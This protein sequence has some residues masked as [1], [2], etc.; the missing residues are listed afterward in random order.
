MVRGE[1]FLPKLKLQEEFLAKQAAAGSLPLAE[2][3][4]NSGCSPLAARCSILHC[5]AGDPQD[6]LALSALFT[7]IIIVVIVIIYYFYYCYS[8]YDSD[9]FFMPQSS[10]S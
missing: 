5:S 7:N 1:V 4:S 2:Q 3:P 6:A 9:V 10:L 8:Y